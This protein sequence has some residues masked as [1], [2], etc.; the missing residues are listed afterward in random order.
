MNACEAYLESKILTADPLELVRMLYREAIE[1]VEGARSALHAGDIPRR[2]QSIN[3]ALMILTELTSSLQHKDVSTIARNLSDLYDYM[4]RR[5]LEAQFQQADPPLAE[6]STLLKTL[7]E[8]WDG[9]RQERALP[10]A[11]GTEPDEQYAQ[12]SCSY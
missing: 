4:Q 9:C 11:M 5:L 1:S 3:R 10:Q 6:V 12:L 2:T 7:L 8:G